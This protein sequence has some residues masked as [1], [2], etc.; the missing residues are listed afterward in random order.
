MKR[1]TVKILAPITSSHK[2]LCIGKNYK[3]Y[4]E[5]QK[6][7]VP[8]EPRVFNKLTSCI[9]GPEDSI[10]YPEET[11]VSLSKF[12]ANSCHYVAFHVY[13]CISFVNKI[14]LYELLS[15]NM[16]QNVF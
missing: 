7:P 8:K 11:K 13:W 1:E 16:E 14:K 4:C 15:K 3:E 9:V 12:L 2:I 5:E 10:I 6:I